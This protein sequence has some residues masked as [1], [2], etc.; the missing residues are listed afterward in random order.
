MVATH[1]SQR[2]RH[3]HRNDS[4]NVHL[5]SYQPLS[6]IESITDLHMGYLCFLTGDKVQALSKLRE[7]TQAQQQRPGS[8]SEPGRCEMSRQ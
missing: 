6:Q 3:A 2:E 7:E 4:K 5:F 1:N 8:C